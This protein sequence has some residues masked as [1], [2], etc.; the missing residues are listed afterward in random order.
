MYFQVC[1]CSDH[2]L[3]DIS[4]SQNKR[5]DCW[6]TSLQGYFLVFPECWLDTLKK[7]AW[8]LLFRSFTQAR[9]VSSDFLGFFPDRVSFGSHSR[10]QLSTCIP[11]QSTAAGCLQPMVSQ[12]FQRARAV[13]GIRTR[14]PFLDLRFCRPR[15]YQTCLPLHRGPTRDR[16]W[17]P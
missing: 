3:Y 2:P 13:G 17:V 5:N 12:S 15:A 4:F 11:N 16:T 1:F 8:P 6:L 7:T 14:V 9:Q 10:M